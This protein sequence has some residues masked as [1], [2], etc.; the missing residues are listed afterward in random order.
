MNGCSTVKLSPNEALGVAAPARCYAGERERRLD[1]P[2]SAAE[3]GR[4]PSP[5]NRLQGGALPERITRTD[6]AGACL[7]R[8]QAATL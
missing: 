6:R 8:L 4:A 1:A 7:E 5:V 3:I 2:P